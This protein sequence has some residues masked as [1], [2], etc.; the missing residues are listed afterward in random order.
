[1]ASCG[2]WRGSDTV[3]VFLLIEKA[4]SLEIFSTNGQI[5][6]KKDNLNLTNK[7]LLIFDFVNTS[8]STFP[9][10]GVKINNKSILLTKMSSQRLALASPLDNAKKATGKVIAEI[11]TT[12][13]TE[14]EGFIY[15]L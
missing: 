8:G 13:I 12:T 9:Y 6:C 14:I 10:L 15:S 7:S 11:V 4:K 5:V 1:M 3:V 2:Y